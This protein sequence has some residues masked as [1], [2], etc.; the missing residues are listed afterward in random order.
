MSQ[1]KSVNDDTASNDSDGDFSNEN[2]QEWVFNDSLCKKKALNEEYEKLLQDNEF[3]GQDEICR[4]RSAEILALAD[5]IKIL[6]YDDALPSGI[7][8]KGD[9]VIPMI[10][11]IVALLE[12]EQNAENDKQEIKVLDEAI[13]TL[14]K[15]VAE[16]TE[17][18]EEE[19][20]DYKTLLASGSTAKEILTI[21]R[22]A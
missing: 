9:R 11:D 16:A 22:I 6:N 21:H 20:S 14:D 7:G 12:K 19:S 10:D 8:R 2:D 15:T 17:N 3:K 13:V 1:K 4:L 5:I 18:R